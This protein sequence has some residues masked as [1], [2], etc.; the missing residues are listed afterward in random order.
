L[1]ESKSAKSPFLLTIPLIPLEK[2]TTNTTSTN[3]SVTVNQTIVLKNIFFETN[4]AQLKNASTAELERLKSLLDENPN[5]RIQLNG[6]TDNVGNDGENMS[7]S[8]NRAKAV[9]DYL[10]KQNIS[11]NRLSYKGFGEN[12]PIASNDTPE[13]RQQNRRTEFLILSF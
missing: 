3:T 4:S 2:T 12:T 7:L 13:G 1:T 6:H 5:M 11:V 10:I 8:N 9:Y